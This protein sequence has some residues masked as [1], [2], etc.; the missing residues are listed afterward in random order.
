LWLTGGPGC[1]S[2]VALFYENGP[3]QFPKDLSKVGP[4]TQ[5][6]NSWNN[7]SNLLYVDQPVGTGFSKA[8]VA[9]D[10]KTEV[11]VAEDM[12]AFLRGFLVANPEYE[13]RDFYITGESYA[14]HY[15]PAIAYYLKNTG[16][17][18]NLK[19]NGVA[20]GNGLTDP[21]AQYPAYPV[22]SYENGLI[23]KEWDTVMTAGMKACQGLIYEAEH[24]PT[25]SLKLEVAATEFCT[26]LSE[27][28]IGN[29]LKPK[30]NVYD[31]REPCTKPPLCYDFS[32]SDT[33]MNDP[34]V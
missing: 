34:V 28:V 23:S 1:A 9:K 22:F 7:I 33:L 17:D 11:E 16:T 10:A 18:I 5:N 12:G 3:Y 24:E 14:G 21:F 30:F 27:T 4:L 29:P 2:E 15:I 31:I 25:K 19:L 32:Q 26:L 6:P 13:G 20:I 8:G